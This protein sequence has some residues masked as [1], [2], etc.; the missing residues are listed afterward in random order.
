MKHLIILLITGSLL[1]SCQSKKKG[2]KELTL[3]E[4]AQSDKQWTGVAISQEGRLFVN[5]P[6][7]SGNVPVS[8]AEVV[9][10]VARAYPDMT[11][12][13]RTGSHSFNAVQSVFIDNKDR[14]WVLDTNN[15]QFKGVNEIGPQ[16][17][18]F[19]L[20]N[21]ELIKI[22]NFPVGVYKPASYFNDVRI[23]TNMNMAYLT[24][25]GDGAL[26]VLNLTTGQSQRLLDDH[27]S[28]KSE[29]DHLMC[30]GRRWENSVDSDGIALSPDGQH[31][32]F[33][34]LTGH[35]LYRISSAALLDESLSPEELAKQV[36]K[37]KKVPATDGMLFDKEGY[38]YLG[39]LENN[40]V[41]RLLPNGDVEQVMQSPR[42]R[43]ADSFT[44]DQEGNLYFTTSQ[45]HLPENERGKYEILM[46]NVN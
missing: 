1:I 16:L 44:M 45:I 2:E 23:D 40:S 20:Q 6:Y 30:N 36:E 18:C 25:S 12:N 22:Y 19:N 7:W 8:V 41:N 5:Y 11:W 13:Q 46:L 17:Y 34:A 24:D 29:S 9:N 10:G 38:L 28:T 37:V 35:T 14:L 26:I 15:P 31:L 21:D 3:S 42:I 39:G 4:I 33:I 43:W 32:Y 27:P